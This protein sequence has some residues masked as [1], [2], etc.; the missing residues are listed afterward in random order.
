MLKEI[1]YNLDS[2]ERIDKYLIT[3]LDF[4]RTKIQ[5]L[6]DEG[7][8]LVNNQIIKANYKLQK[9]DVITVL[10]I[11]EEK[12]DNNLK[13]Y[14]LDLDIIY[15]DEDIIIINKPKG[16]VVHPGAGN[17][18]NTLVNAL[19]AHS[20]KL[21]SINGEYRP[22]IVHRLDK[23]TAGLLV[24]AKNDK[25]HLHIA[26]QLKD[27]SCSRKYYAL[28][29]GV[30]ENKQIRI[31]APIARSKKNRQK[32]C[33]A[34]GGKNAITNVRLIKS[35]ADFSLVECKLETGRTHQIRVHMAYIKH[36]IINDPLYGD[37]II[38]DS[39]QYLFAYHLSLNH[40][41]TIKRMDF[42][43]DLPSDFKEYMIENG[44]NN[45]L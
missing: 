22:G 13:A 24:I 41:T 25:A 40:P 38:D 20:K 12:L 42:S 33:V 26:N 31:I 18:D 4:S 34:S 35:F 30:I 29:K 11:I 37:K 8:I 9:G 27:R 28:V 23:D 7:K 2:N 19:I 21:S 5:K 44:G 6:I 15:E 43:I 14:N 1:N 16:L 32:M 3:E 36:P 45:A 17:F 10:N 39:G